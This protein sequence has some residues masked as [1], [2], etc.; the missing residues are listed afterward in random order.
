LVES[1][2][3]FENSW[4]E[5]DDWNSKKGYGEDYYGHSGYHAE[6]RQGKFSNQMAFRE[7]KLEQ[8]SIEISP[9]EYQRLRG[10]DETWRAIQNDFYMPYECSCCCRTIFCIQDANFILC[11][12]CRV[13]SP[14]PGVYGG[15]DGGVGLGFTIEKL[16]QWQNDIE[17]ERIATRKQYN[18]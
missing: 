1:E 2:T 15:S 17:R 9:G 7:K 16:A 13:V 10:A 8:T 18:G 4:N 3:S 5:E 12:E 11:P 6:D 14:M